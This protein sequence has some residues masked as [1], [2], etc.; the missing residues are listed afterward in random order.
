MRLYAHFLRLVQSFSCLGAW[1][2]R[3][4]ALWCYGVILAEGCQIHAVA[5]ALVSIQRASADALSER[6]TRFLS[7]PRISDE[8]LSAAWVRWLA[9]THVSPHWVILV[10]ET[11]LSNY[12][13]VMMVGLAYRGRAIPLLWRCY[14]PDAYPSEGQVALIV[15][16]L[17][18]LRLLI[19][20]EIA[21]TVQAD[22]G[23]GT[24]SDLIRQLQRLGI[25]FLLLVTSLVSQ[26]SG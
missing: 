13:S 7:N 6:L 22:R 17:T 15:E 11:K 9:Q 26:P 18:R 12:L 16:L 5:D 3:A 20:N 2:K 21:L 1:Q 24:F 14:A 4:L 10:D 25:D 23:I 19:P 8:L